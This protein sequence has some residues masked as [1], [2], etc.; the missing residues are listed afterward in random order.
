M[1][2]ARPRPG[3]TETSVYTFPHT[4]AALD[5]CRP[6]KALRLTFWDVNKENDL[7]AAVGG[8]FRGTASASRPVLHSGIQT[9]RLIHSSASLAFQISASSSIAI[10][11]GMA[12]RSRMTPGL[13]A[14]AT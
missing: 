7:R 6:P 2:E 3:L 13:C 1:A 14:I 8:H 5:T 9:N 11:M 10:E 12:S 4:R